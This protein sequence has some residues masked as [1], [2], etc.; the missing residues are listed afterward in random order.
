MI[1]WGDNSE[2]TAENGICLRIDGNLLSQLASESN[3]LTAELENPYI[4]I[5]EKKIS[6]MRDLLPVLEKIAQSGKP[7]LIIAEEVE[8]EAPVDR[9]GDLPG[10]LGVE[11]APDLAGVAEP[12]DFIV[13]SPKSGQPKQMA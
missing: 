2:I 1:H 8:G 5:H 12:S 6:S 9:L 10:G 13:K 3:F 11:L 4:L 7:L